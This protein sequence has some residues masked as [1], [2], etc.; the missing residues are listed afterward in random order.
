METE[1]ELYEQAF[2]KRFPSMVDVQGTHYDQCWKAHPTCAYYMGWMDAM[3]NAGKLIASDD[4][5]Y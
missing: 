4:T 3:R 1:E 2:A 5:Q